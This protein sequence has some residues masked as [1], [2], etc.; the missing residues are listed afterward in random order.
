MQKHD[1]FMTLNLPIYGEV[2]I[3]EGKGL[4]W[5]RAMSKSQ[6]DSSCFLKCLCLELLVVNGKFV[7]EQFLDN[8]PL[9]DINYVM[10]VVSTMIDNSFNI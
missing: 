8:M 10:T 5:F 6:K 4:H 2:G 3:I 9:K 1:F 7:D